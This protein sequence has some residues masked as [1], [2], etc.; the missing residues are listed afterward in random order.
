MSH[1]DKARG[2]ITFDPPVS[3]AELEGYS[4][5]IPGEYRDE[6]R[7]SAWLE[8]R[9]EKE[10]TSE[11]ILIRQEAIGIRRSKEKNIDPEDL[12]NRV[13][14]MVEAFRFL[15]DGSGSQRQ[16]SGEIRVH[17]EDMGEDTPDVWRV[18]VVNSEVS[19]QRP[20]LLWPDGTTEKC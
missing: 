1:S 6:Y 2:R 11:G 17:G 16:F 9:K 7:H 4:R 13:E 15:P 8:I 20:K 18:V 3:W 12:V 19:V 14:A 10:R 5:F